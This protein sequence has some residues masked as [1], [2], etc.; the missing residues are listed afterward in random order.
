[1]VALFKLKKQLCHGIEL[2]SYNR[3][4]YIL[5]SD[6][7]SFLSRCDFWIKHLCFI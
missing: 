6:R 2:S 5:F 7:V 4:H 3:L 1:M